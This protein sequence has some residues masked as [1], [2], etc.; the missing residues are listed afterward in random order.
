MGWLTTVDI[1]VIARQHGCMARRRHSQQES[2]RSAA[3]ARQREANEKAAAAARERAAELRRLHA[4]AAARHELE[5][6]WGS[7]RDGLARLRDIS[8]QLDK[9]HRAERSLLHERDNL[10][11]ALRK[12]DVS[13][14]MLS[15][16]S[17]LSRQAMS[18]RATSLTPEA[19]R[20]HRV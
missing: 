16:W 11:D 6:V 20:T 17:G 5:L 3:Y 4:E 12:T 7:Q 10:I 8:K 18:K 9:L 1:D 14:A 19:G 2:R 13:W 15:S